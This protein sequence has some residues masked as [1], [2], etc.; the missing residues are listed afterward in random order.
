MLNSGFAQL[1]SSFET[2]QQLN[3]KSESENSSFDRLSVPAGSILW[4]KFVASENKVFFSLKTENQIDA[5]NF[6][7]FDSSHNPLPSESILP[8]LNG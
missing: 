2:A 6:E 7:F 8:M 5:A 3:I 1:G 4:I